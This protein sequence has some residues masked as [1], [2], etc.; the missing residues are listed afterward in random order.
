M[1]D[2]LAG[3]RALV[4]GAG[5]GIGRAVAARFAAEG[6][7]V[8]VLDVDRG[9][10]EDT[11]EQ[12]RG[13]GGR[14]LAVTADVSVEQQVAD[15]YADAVGALGGLDIVV[16]NAAV[17]LFGADALVHELDA[18]V[19]DRTHAVNLRGAFLTCKHGVR[20]LLASGG[21]SLICTGSPTGMYGGAYDF[22]AYSAS[23][24]GVHGMA[25]AIAIGYAQHGIRCNIVVPGFTATPLVAGILESPQQLSKTL[26]TVPMRRPGRPDDVA[27]TMVFLASDEASFIT[28]ALYTVDGGQ[29]AI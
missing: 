13:D 16:V 18:A 7:P 15:A 2:R 21:G 1:G 5:S 8:V 10:A 28:G 22:T 12:I 29:T 11:A 19:W 24:A 23:K 9:A 3:K 27:A 6:A 25:R 20:A 14:A 17:Q 26:A 4:T